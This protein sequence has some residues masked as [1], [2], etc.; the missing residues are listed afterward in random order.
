MHKQ[1][2][3]GYTLGSIVLV[4]FILYTTGIK[5]PEGKW[6]IMG[7]LD[8]RETPIATTLE[9]I[10]Y[11]RYRYAEPEVHLFTLETEE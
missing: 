6:V 1:F 4:I 7:Q 10:D 3:A 9:P 2:I 5:T 11:Y 8:C